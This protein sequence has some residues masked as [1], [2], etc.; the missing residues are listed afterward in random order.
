MV[1]LKSI[2]MNDGENCARK[3]KGLFEHDDSLVPS[4]L[5][6]QDGNEIERK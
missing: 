4:I 1:Q 3:N 6:S 5:T 2:Q